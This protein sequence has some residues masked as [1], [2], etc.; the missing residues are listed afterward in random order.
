M[1]KIIGA[2]KKIYNK[3]TKKS[4][5]SYSLCV[6]NAQQAKELC[7]RHAEYSLNTEERTKKIIVSL[8]SFPAR[9][10]HLHLVI[11]GIL[12]QTVKPDELILYLDD[13][14]NE[15]DVPDS[16]KELEKYGLQ[17]RFR[18]ANIKP[19]KKYYY[20]MKEHPDD[21]VITVDDDII[22][23]SGLIEG[24]LQTHIRYP[25]C[26]VA[27]RA[28]RILFDSNGLPIEYNKWDWEW[29]IEN[30]PSLE[31]VATGVGGVLYPPHCMSEHLLDLDLINKLSLNNDDL[32]LK[33]M[34]VLVGTK[35]VVCDRRLRENRMLVPDSQEVSLNS[36]NVH[37]SAND[38]YMSQ[39]MEYFK[40]SI[41]NF[42]GGILLLTPFN[43]TNYGTKLQAY[44]VQEYISQYDDV[45]IINYQ[46]DFWGR[47]KR[48]IEWIK[49]KK[50]SDVKSS[51]GVK[52]MP[53]EW[54]AKRR[55]SINRFNSRLKVAPV[56]VG[57]N[58]LIEKTA[59]CKA[60]V[61]GS[62]QIWNPVNLGQHV[63]ML[64]FVAKGA[65]RISFAASFGISKLPKALYNTYKSRLSNIDYISVRESTGCDIVEELGYN[66][67]ELLDPTLLLEE[68]KWNQLAAC[69]AD[70]VPDEPYI[71]C[72]FLG[73]HKHG[74]DVA[75]ELSR[76]YGGAAIVNL[77]HFK[78]YVPYDDGFADID[79]NEVS[80]ESFLA[81]IKNAAA[82]CTDSFHGSAFSV[83]FEKDLYCVE[84]HSGSD[85]GNTNDRVYS[86]LKLL[87]ISERMI[88]Q[89]SDVFSCKEIDYTIVK[90][91][92]NEKREDAARFFA[93]V[94]NDSNG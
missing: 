60:V 6:M 87:G 56:T 66:A 26:V 47:V 64:E 1:S 9:F 54:V 15:E 75:K 65:K 24:L 2:A 33:I 89:Q 20:A 44:A 81:L 5:S 19:H 79:L 53:E 48:K 13:N 25:K 76:K 91:M 49:I 93:E 40:L 4:A 74:R 8:T 83:I 52:N 61:C 73:N 51:K 18:P 69:G 31:L 78:Q 42:R 88:T 68:E 77:P 92:L 34:Q 43:V 39:L 90:A 84:R 72:Y 38:I 80:V 11:R 29:K 27:T 22:Y 45:E 35:V 94:F 63:Y 3:V 36:T 14:V 85:K 71:I 10:K 7:D 23:P 70:I 37:K 41:D 67:V 59:M 62:D 12:L 82:V 50:Y 28:H 57:M 21:I 17:I 30:I 58:N 55:A 16:L 32:W 86:V 46:P